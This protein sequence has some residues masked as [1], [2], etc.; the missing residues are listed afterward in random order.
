M[1]THE[2]LEAIDTQIAQ[3]Q[4]ARALLSDA[5]VA[6]QAITAT[7][8]PS[9]KRRGRPKGSVAKKLE[10]IASTPAKKVRAT[11]SAEGKAR[12]AAAQKARWAALKKSSNVAKPAA[13]KSAVK[14]SK[15]T[16]TPTKKAVAAERAP[17][18]KSVAPTKEA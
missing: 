17:A 6:A 9:G 14:Q 8:K 11:M 10:S 12:I 16:V 15:K 4:Q 1:N 3:L 2:I 18:V 13:K 7:T 5:P